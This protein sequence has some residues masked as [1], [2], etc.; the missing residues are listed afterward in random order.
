MRSVDTALTPAPAGK[1][2]AG[3]IFPAESGK[4]IADAG[5]IVGVEAA[6]TTTHDGFSGKA[7][8]LGE[9]RGLSG[10]RSSHGGG[11]WN[12]SIIKCVVAV[13]VV[14]GPLLREQRGAASD[15]IGGGGT[16][17]TAFKCARGTSS[18]VRLLLLPDML[19]RRITDCVFADVIPQLA[20]GLLLLLLSLV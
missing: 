5:D 11:D 1:Y 6:G 16:V 9:L 15:T 20:L 4:V 7:Q 2:P 3:I 12:F 14:Q 8:A 19:Y 13:I 10:R 18:S 17:F